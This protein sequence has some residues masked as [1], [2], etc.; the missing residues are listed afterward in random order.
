ME[1]KTWSYA[2]IPLSRLGSHQCLLSAN[3]QHNLCP[4]GW[5]QG[6]LEWSTLRFEHLH[7][8]FGQRS[9]R[10]TGLPSMLS[11]SQQA[12]CLVRA[13]CTLPSSINFRCSYVHPPGPADD[14]G[15]HCAYCRKTSSDSAP[16]ASGINSRTSRGNSLRCTWGLLSCNSRK[17]SSVPGATGAPVR[18]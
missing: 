3:V 15:V 6:E 10:T 12:L 16:Q 7:E 9:H 14:P 5:T 13:N 17:V 8:L 11:Q 4:L 2:P 18:H 1:R